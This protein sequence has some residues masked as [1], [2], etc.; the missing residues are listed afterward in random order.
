[1]LAKWDIMVP[2]GKKWGQ[3]SLKLRLVKKINKMLV[4]LSIK[5]SL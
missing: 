5:T 3:T 2:S 4:Y 1:M